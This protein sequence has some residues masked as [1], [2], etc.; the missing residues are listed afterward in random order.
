L[1]SCVRKTNWTLYKDRRI[2]FRVELQFIVFT[3]D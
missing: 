3:G 2:F 1:C